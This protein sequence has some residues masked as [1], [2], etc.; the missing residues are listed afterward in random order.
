M[1]LNLER[2]EGYGKRI[3]RKISI[4]RSY[5]FGFPPV[6]MKE[7]SLYGKKFCSLFYDKD[8]QVIG[9]KFHNNDEEGGFKMISYGADDSKGASIVSR[10]FFTTYGIDPTK[11]RGKYEPKL[12]NIDNIGDVF[13]IDLNEINQNQS[14]IE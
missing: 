4:N 9:L 7:N 10:S 12:K 8:Q 6:F 5:S 1:N 2:F 3:S 11:Y 14:P 13:L